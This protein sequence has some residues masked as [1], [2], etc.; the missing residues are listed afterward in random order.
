ML[1]AP[2]QEYRSRLV[3]G[4]AVL[5]ALTAADARF[6]YARL[7]A[8]LAGVTLAVIAWHGIV[9]GWWLL[10]PGLVFLFLV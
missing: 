2:D 6:A 7:T 5:D 3:A 1:R 4:R 8:F 10:A 9:S